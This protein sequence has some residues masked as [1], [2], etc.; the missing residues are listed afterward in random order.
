MRKGMALRPDEVDT[1]RIVPVFV[2][3]SFFSLGNWPGPYARLR[4]PEIGLTWSVVL[5]H[6]VMRYVEFAM[7]QHW[8][9]KGIDWKALALRN[10]AEHSGDKPGSHQLH[11]SNGEIYA[12]A[13]MHPDGLG[14]SRLLFRERLSAFFAAGYRVALPEMS[15][16]FAFSVNLEQQELATVRKLIDDCYRN[17][18]RPLASGIFAPEDLLPEGDVT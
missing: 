4:A 10:L 16:A 5:P 12:F 11:R 15:C 1:S 8:E 6:Q 7:Q 13:F 3:A 9:A 2:P 14:P 18:T 17:G